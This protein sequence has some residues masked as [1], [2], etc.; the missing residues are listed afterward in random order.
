MSIRLK[1]NSNLLKNAFSNIDSALSKDKESVI[2]YYCC[3]LDG[4]LF[5]IYATNQASQTSV[6]ILASIEGDLISNNDSIGNILTFLVKKEFLDIIKSFTGDVVLD[7]ADKQVAIKNGK[8][9]TR[10]K[11]LDADGYPFFAKPDS[12]QSKKLFSMPFGKLKTLLKGVSFASLKDDNQVKEFS[13]ILLECAENKIHTVATNRSML[14]HEYVEY[15]TENFYGILEFEGVNQLSRIH[16][17][18]DKNVDVHAYFNSEQ[19]PLFISF[20]FMDTGD[21]NLPSIVA[22]VRIIPGI[23]PNYS[24]LSII[25]QENVNKITINAQELL[26][27]LEKINLIAKNDRNNTV[28]FTISKGNLSV[29]YKNFEGEDTEDEIA[30]T[31]AGEY[32]QESDKTETISFNLAMVINFL[33]NTISKDTFDFCWRNPV[34]PV[35]CYIN[36]DEFTESFIMVPIR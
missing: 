5:S 24:T 25:G 27:S 21:S 32:G 11:I 10:T 36:V 1:F 9:V 12:L 22:I 16:V 18:D 30:L 35:E 3:T 7:I 34:K 19:K 13:G 4:N 15:E 26:S 17:D 20:T 28:D 2:S 23:L 29:L 6:G 31:D 8:F 33:R 14:D